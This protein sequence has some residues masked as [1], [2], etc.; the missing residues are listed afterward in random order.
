MRDTSA[1]GNQVGCPFPF[2]YES[3]DVV[4][5]RLRAS[6]QAIDCLTLV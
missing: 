3:G 1:N 4:A 2:F 6:V 5:T